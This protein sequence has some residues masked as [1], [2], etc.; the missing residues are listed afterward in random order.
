VVVA[1]RQPLFR[2]G[3]ADVIAD[4][5]DLVVVGE[6]DDASALVGTVTLQ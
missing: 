4:E 5:P 3:V 6:T 1:D 2:R